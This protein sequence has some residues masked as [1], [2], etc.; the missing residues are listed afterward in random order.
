[1][2][3]VSGRLEIR[4]LLDSLITPNRVSA[5]PYRSSVVI[6]KNG[7]QLTGQIVNLQGT[8]ITVQTDPLRPFTRVDIPFSDIET[9]LS[10]PVSLMPEGLLDSLTLEEIL[11]LFAYLLQ[12]PPQPQAI[13]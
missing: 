2:T 11:D 13:R 4:D 1:M 6:R 8:S 3:G 5:E 7:T 9:T 10:S 12:Q